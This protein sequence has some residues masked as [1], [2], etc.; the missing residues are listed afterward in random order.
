[1]PAPDHIVLLLHLLV[2]VYWL[3]GDI[4]VFYSSFLLTDSKRDTAGRIAA[5]KILNDV[6]LVPRICLLLTL[7]TGLAV[8]ASRGWMSIDVALIVAAFVIAIIWIW[9][10]FALHNQSG[11]VAVFRRIDAGLRWLFCSGLVAIPIA[12][13]SGA[14]DIPLFIS[15]K[16]LLLAVAILMGLFV[17]NALKPFAPAFAKLVAGDADAVTNET[18]RSCLRRARPAV[19]AIWITLIAAAMLGIAT[20]I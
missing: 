14:I 19:I 3:G 5:A 12:G 4:G 15:L 9:L 11:P 8:A 2:F 13:I 6:D 1:M 10:L 16:M 17:R 18:I 7:P 20:P